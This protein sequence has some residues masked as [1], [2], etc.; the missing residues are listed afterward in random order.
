V[1][2]AL[3][4]PVRVNRV[5][6]SIWLNDQGSLP[7][8][9]RFFSSSQRGAHPAYYPMGA[10]AKHPGYNA[11][12][13]NHLQLMSRPRILELYHHFPILP[14]ATVLN[15]FNT[16]TTLPFNRVFQ[17]L[18]PS[19]KCRQIHEINQI[20]SGGVTRWVDREDKLQFV[21]T[22]VR[23]CQCEPV[24]EGGEEQVVPASRKRRQKGN[25]VPGGITGPLC[26]WG[27]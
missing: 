24:F 19:A 16:R 18:N 8:G 3:A 23:Y 13:T 1:P 10:G 4:S 14:H 22:R 15:A 21:S 17:V 5:F 26:S 11:S 20:K 6:L 27:I 12:G 2:C 9:P 7:G 25:P